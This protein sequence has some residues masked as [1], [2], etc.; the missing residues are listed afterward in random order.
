MESSFVKTWFLAM[1]PKTLWAAVSP[2]IVGT[3][4]AYGDGFFHVAIFAVT[5]ACAI[6]IQI[7][8]NFANDYYD[9]IKG[10]DTEERMGPTRATQAGWVTPQIMKRAFIFTFAIAFFCGLYLAWHGGMYILLIGIV[11]I[12]CGVI[13][14]GGPYPLGYNGLGD[15]FVL[16]FFGPVAVGGTYYLQTLNLQ[17]VHIFC[18]LALGA[19]ATAIIIVNNLRDMETDR[20][21]GKR[22]LAVRFGKTFTYAEYALC[23]M[24]A[25]ALPVYLY[26]ANIKGINILYT[27]LPAPIACALFVKI[28]RVEGKKL[29][30][31]LGQTALILLLFSI[32]FSVAWIWS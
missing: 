3:A 18:G 19:L 12:I 17:L 11:S 8:T 24:G 31:V 16:I 14:T 4:M 5:M 28:L 10:A 22:T 7:G 26:L 30:P 13:Y 29:N 1:R 15:I 32:C 20:K 27:L 9:F 23:F 6:A 25:F 2:V 21:V